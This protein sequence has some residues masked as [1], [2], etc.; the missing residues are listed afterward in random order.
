MNDAR[1]VNNVR[2]FQRLIFPSIR[3]TL[4]RYHRLLLKDLALSNGHRLSFRQDMLI[5]KC[6]IISN[7]DSDRSL[8]PTRLRRQLRVLT[9]RKD[10]CHRLIKRVKISS[11]D[12]PLRGLTRSR[13]KVFLLTRISSTRRRRFYL[14]TRSTC[15]TVTRR[16]NTKVGARSSFLYIQF[17][18]GRLG[19]LGTMSS[20]VF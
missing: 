10:L 8:H 15:R 1:N 14:I 7:N 16:I 9:R 4:R 5:S 20:W 2:M 6:I 3:R 18:L 19:L 13:M 17:F 12:R 11:T